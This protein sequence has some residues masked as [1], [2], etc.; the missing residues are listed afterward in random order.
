MRWKSSIRR[1]VAP[2]GLRHHQA[3][4]MLRTSKRCTPHE[5]IHAEPKAHAK[6]NADPKAP[7]ASGILPCQSLGEC[8]ARDAAL[9]RRQ[10]G[11]N[12]AASVFVNETSGLASHHPKLAGVYRART[13]L[14]CHNI[15]SNPQTSSLIL[16]AVEF[17]IGARSPAGASRRTS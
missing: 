9:A 4:S 12:G 15:H 7:L 17:K 10:C 14:F 8:A 5:R 3:T 2:H 1:S 16:A 13:F 6:R 11:P